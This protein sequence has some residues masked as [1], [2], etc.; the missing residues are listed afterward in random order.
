MARILFCALG[1]VAPRFANAQDK[2]DKAKAATAPAPAAV[3]FEF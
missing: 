3:V 1:L 2:K